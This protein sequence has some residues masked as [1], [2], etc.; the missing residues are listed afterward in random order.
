MTID[1]MT[2]DIVLVDEQAFVWVFTK[3]PMCKWL[4]HFDWAFVYHAGFNEKAL[5][6]SPPGYARA[7][8]VFSL[9]IEQVG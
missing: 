6:G 9:Q 8:P 1:F 7:E 4:C 5:A 2:I 3:L